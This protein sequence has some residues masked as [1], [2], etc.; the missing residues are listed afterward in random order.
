MYLYPG[1]PGY[2]YVPGD[3]SYGDPYWVPGPSAPYFLT[4]SLPNG[5]K[6][7]AYSQFLAVAGGTPAYTFAVTA[8]AL[9]AGITL[10]AGTGEIAG[11]PTVTGSFTFIVTVTDSDALT[12]SANLTLYI[13]SQPAIANSSLPR[14][15]VGTPYFG[16]L[17]GAGGAVPYGFSVISGGLPP[18]L[19]L[20]TTG[21]ITG[22]PTTAGNY[23][24][25]IQIADSSLPVG[26]NSSAFTIVIGPADIVDAVTSMDEVVL[27][28]GEDGAL[29]GIVPGQRHDEDYDGNPVGFLQRWNGV[30][31]PASMA[32]MQ[33]GG[34]T[35]SAKGNGALNVFA[36]DDDGRI[37]HLSNDARPMLLSEV[38]TKRDFMAKGAI[39]S[40][41]F[42]IG[43]DN[44]AVA[45][46]WFEV[47]TA[48][49]WLRQF[50]SSRRA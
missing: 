4:S 49:L 23:L 15:T 6:G 9:P 20:A 13:P 22:I 19:T 7:A 39:H 2:P 30:G 12:G 11:T 45:D 27:I 48:I 34:A 5:A 38:E 10:N 44:G 16:S 17:I 42:G 31:G 50:F 14:G 18:G 28:A 43:F 1:D 26:T 41:R 40:E 46:A 36:T 3:P 47:H 25:T 8:G 29:Y 24:V 37:V 33:I 32:L 35:V 21:G